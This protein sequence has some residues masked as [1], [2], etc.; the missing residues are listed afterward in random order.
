MTLNFYYTEEERGKIME[1]KKVIKI[2]LSSFL[3]ILAV[4]IIVIMGY[5]IYELYNDKETANNKVEEL[6]NQLNNLEDTVNILQEGINN[7]SNTSQ[8]NNING[9]TSSNNEIL[10]ANESYDEIILNGS[11]GSKNSE[12]GYEF[13]S[14]GKVK[15]ITT[16]TDKEGTY[17]TIGENEIE[18]TFVK[19]TEWDPINV[20]DNKSTTFQVNEK[21]K[22]KYVDENTLI[23]EGTEENEYTNTT[24]VKL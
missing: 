21:E 6:S 9:E 1:E 17:T 13:T 12:F 7:V 8:L 16:F 20:D 11:Y 3:L 4:I 15:F 19:K 14:D 10:D 22:I 2:S 18:L 5:F 23:L 24:L